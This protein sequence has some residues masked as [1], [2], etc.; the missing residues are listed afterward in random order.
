MTGKLHQAL[1]GSAMLCIAISG[2]TLFLLAI[3]GKTF[4][5]CAGIT[6]WFLLLFFLYFAKRGAQY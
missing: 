6:L 1:R 3:T 5:Q 2:P 4:T